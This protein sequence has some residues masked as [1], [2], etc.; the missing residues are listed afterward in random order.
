MLSH[1]NAYALIIRGDGMRPKELHVLNTEDVKCL[2]V[3]GEA[4]YQVKDEYVSGENLLHFKMYSFDGIKGVSPILYNAEAFGYRIKQDKYKAQVLGTKPPGLLSYDGALTS[5][6]TKQA[7]EMWKRMTQ[8]N[9]LGGTP[10]L[11]GGAKYQPFM[12]P[13]NEGQMIESAKLSRE[14]IAGIYRVPPTMIQDY[15]RA[16][17]S[18]AE[19]QDLVYLKYSLTP[20][21]KVIEQE[22]DYKLFSIRTPLYTKFNIKAM[23]RGDIKTQ[24]EWYRTLSNIG[25]FSIN[26]IRG[27]EDL[28]PVADGDQR[29]IQGAMIPID[30]IGDFYSDQKPEKDNSQR[31]LGFDIKQMKDQL[32]RIEIMNDGK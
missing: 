26:D 28:P 22:C 14:E 23:L 30:K 20:I 16:T 9:E 11:G 3:N 32:D 31:A 27:F 29:F 8:G 15:E 21:L 25:V 4:V 7:S 10:V 19:Q 24:A 2:V 18:N 6:Q 1:G 12:I 5:E 13:P 17:F